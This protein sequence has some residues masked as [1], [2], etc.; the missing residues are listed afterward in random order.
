[1]PKVVSTSIFNADGIETDVEF[2]VETVMA[3]TLILSLVTD[4]GTAIV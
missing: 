2:S 3:E 4:E 1:V